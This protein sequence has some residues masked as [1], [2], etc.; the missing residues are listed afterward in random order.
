MGVATLVV[1]STAGSFLPAMPMRSKA[2]TRIAHFF[3]VCK[4]N[5]LLRKKLA[6]RFFFLSGWKCC[7]FGGCFEHGGGALRFCGRETAPP[8][9]SVAG[10]RSGRG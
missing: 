7:G 3:G 4:I 6:V 9:P 8:L 5:F 1:W 2:R 10:L